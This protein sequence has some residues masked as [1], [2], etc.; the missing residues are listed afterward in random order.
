MIL[1]GYVADSELTDHYQM[2]DL[3][4][5]PS[6]GEGFGI[7]F[8]EAMV[9]GLSVI[10]GNKDGSVDALKNGD[11]G[12]LID[13]DNQTEIIEA[14]EKYYN[15]RVNVNANSKH[16]LQKEVI[17]HFGFA[18]FKERMKTIVEIS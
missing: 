13:P 9:C 17:Q 3:F 4:I 11:L 8:L 15:N 6:K 2:S 14:V 1:A 7:V 16:E 18:T 12:M 5:M 10:A